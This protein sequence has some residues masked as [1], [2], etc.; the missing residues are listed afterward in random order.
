L[1]PESTKALRLAHI[2]DLHVLELGGTGPGQFLNKRLTGYINLVVHRRDGHPVEVTERLVEDLR[3]QGVDH[4]AVTGDVTN[5]SLASEFRRAVE[6]LTPLGDA[7]QLSVIPG[8]H[9]NYVRE[10]NAEG[11][12]E[13][14]FEPWLQGDHTHAD[15]AH[16]PFLKL[17]GPVALIGLSS[18][19]PTSWL[20]ATGEVGAAQLERLQTILGLDSLRERFKVV[21]I[22]HPLMNE[23]E[24]PWHGMRRLKDESE[25]RRVLLE[26]GVDLVLHGHNH[27]RHRSQ[28]S[29]N[30]TTV[31][32]RAA[33]SASS[34]GKAHPNVWAQYEIY[35][36]HPDTGLEEVARRSFDKGAGRFLGV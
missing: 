14:F 23:P 6:I 20:H 29:D 8:N 26:H 4:V 35:D 2:S 32:V 12:F 16:Y 25:V 19:I 28:F 27:Y 31:Q 18:A 5:L 21:L 3:E 13:H 33:A 1:S 7:R 22:H 9:D 17:L 10:S 11:R 15:G 34:V 36:I 24:R 30:G